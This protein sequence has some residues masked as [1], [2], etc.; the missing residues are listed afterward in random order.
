MATPYNYHML[1]PISEEVEES[2]NAETHESQTETYMPDCELFH[3]ARYD[4]YSTLFP[5]KFHQNLNWAEE[6]DFR[7]MEMLF[8]DPQS[9]SALKITKDVSN[10]FDSGRHAE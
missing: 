8:D 7:E 9:E 6:E 3:L 1:A 4:P 10:D 5:G 2:P